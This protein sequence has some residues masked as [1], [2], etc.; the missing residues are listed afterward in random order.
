MIKK[1]IKRMKWKNHK[2]KLY[3]GNIEIWDE[4][5]KLWISK[6]NKINNLIFIIINYI[7]KNYIKKK[8][9]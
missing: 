8:L 2:S 3:T 1:E 9:L 5:K 4:E 7:K 6:S